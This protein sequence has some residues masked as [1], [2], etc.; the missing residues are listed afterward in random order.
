MGDISIRVNY[1][2]TNNSNLVR[3]PYKMDHTITPEIETNIINMNGFITQTIIG[4]SYRNSIE[5]K[6]HITTTD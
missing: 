6:L 5:Q 4:K 2:D 3:R 1:A